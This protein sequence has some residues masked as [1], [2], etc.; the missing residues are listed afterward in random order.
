MREQDY[1]DTV[2]YHCG[3]KL[4]ENPAPD[5]PQDRGF[6]FAECEA[7]TLPVI[8]HLADLAEHVGASRPDKEAVARRLYKDTRCGISFW[9]PNVSSV[10]IAGYCEGSERACPPH[11]FTFPFRAERFDVAVEEADDEGCE[12]WGDTHGCEDCNTSEIDGEKP[13]DPN[14]AKCGGAGIVI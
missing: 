5:T 1:D 11:V 9:M 8:K 2:C 13:V 7:R 3:E 12:V 10:G 14:C 4:I 6:C